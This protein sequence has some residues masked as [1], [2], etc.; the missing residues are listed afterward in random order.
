MKIF[1]NERMVDEN[2]AA[3]SVLDRG[4]LYGDGLFE[5][6]RSY[7]GEVLWLDR[8]LNRLYRSSEI[9]GMKINR[10]KKYLKYI[11][12]KLIKVND[13]KDAYIR[14]CVTR[15]KGR[16]GLETT[17]V[18]D[19]GLVV[20]AKKF[21]PYPDRL[22]K[23]GVSLKTSTI[24]RNEK[25]DTSKVKSLNY[26]DSILAR[27]E[28]QRE[29]A[30]DALLLNTKGF[31]AESAVSNI[32]MIKRKSLITP[33]LDS[34]ALPGITRETILS[35]AEE[36]SLEPVEKHIKLDDLK[37]ASEIFLSNSLMEVMPVA[38]IDGKKIGKS[39][40]GL[41]TK[42]IHKLYRNKISKK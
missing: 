19:Q 30:D 11:I 34:G 13:L 7:K 35:L 32:F 23:K 2:K 37:R 31:V 25:S 12:Y 40:A 4:F 28:A 29:G 36:L 27:I 14:L 9:I 1:V 41:V 22:Y 18:R 38:S 16:I 20:M 8:H 3:I 5:T 6:M 26:M 10:D 15:G 21:E 39:T 17:A 24:R 42:A 33:S